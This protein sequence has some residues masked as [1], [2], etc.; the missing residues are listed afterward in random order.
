MSFAQRRAPAPGRQRA[1]VARA[2]RWIAGGLGLALVLAPGAAMA[3]SGAGGVGVGARF[4]DRVVLLGF[5][6]GV[7][8]RQRL[9]LERA[10][11]GIGARSLGPPVKQASTPAPG[12]RAVPV[13]L[14]LRVAHGRVLAVVSRLRRSGEVAYAEPDYLMQASAAPNDFSFGMQWADSNSGQPIPTQESKEVL[15]PPQSGTPGAD[16]GALKAWGVSTGSPSIV[17]GEA[18]TGLDYS[19]PDLAAN[20]WANPGGIGG[21]P[22]G[23]HGYN[24]VSHTCNPMDD[25]TAFGGHGS[26]VAGIIGA[27]GNNGVGVAGV[28]WSTTILPVKWLNSSAKG[29]TSALIEALAWLL[30]AKET[31]VNIRVVNDSATF[32]GTEPSQALS[33]EI[34]T[35][36]AHGI[37]FVTAAGN[38]GDNND[39]KSVRRYPCGYDRPTEI[40][41]T[42]TDNNDQLPSWA[43]YGPN[44]VDLAAPGVSIYSTLRGGSYGYLSGG[45]M[46]TAQVSGA[47]A[48]I[49]SVAPSLSPQQLKSDIVGN[50]DP[51]PSLTGKVISGS[52]LDI[53]KAMPGCPVQPAPPPPPVEPPPPPAPP[54]RPPP[55]IIR[56]LRIS[57]RAF[58]ATSRSN[59]HHNKGV[60]ATGAWISYTDSLPALVKFTLFKLEAGIKNK[61]HVCAKRRSHAPVARSRRCSRYWSVG[62][63]RRR[64][65]VGANRR[66][67]GGVF[68]GRELEPG[69]YRLVLVP[70]AEGQTGPARAVAFRVTRQADV[71][72]H[73]PAP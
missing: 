8:G 37:L 44:T 26:H 19:H 62:A 28:N 59:R 2:L 52:R 45:S 64:D 60:G 3:Q 4:R 5:R 32:E 27:V 68:H 71:A 14:E 18:D 16:D 54:Q 55:P 36:G 29:E 31:G 66:R 40:C 65:R 47:A 9:A 30:A 42:A 41:V 38:T 49:L 56:R 72:Q 50:A 33:D 15:G 57:P 39:V 61:A 25:D 58:A 46:A 48:L 69:S 53:C 70:S 21:C 23:T 67:L 1:L 63:L 11:G 34:D 24:F 35:L 51:L 10:V 17:I 6:P 22:S 20:V 43:N 13:P 7:S 12:G 73:A